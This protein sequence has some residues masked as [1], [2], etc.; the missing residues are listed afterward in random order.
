MLRLSCMVSLLK[1]N[2]QAVFANFC[3]ELLHWSDITKP[4][5]PNQIEDLILV[6]PDTGEERT[7]YRS[8]YGAKVKDP[9][10][11]AKQPPVSVC[12]NMTHRCN[13]LMLV[14]RRRT[15][16]HMS[17]WSWRCFTATVTANS[18]GKT[19]QICTV[20]LRAPTF[21]LPRL[22]TRV[23]RAKAKKDCGHND[24]RSAACIV[25]RIN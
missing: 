18:H 7:A 24:R 11:K 13:A 22:D 5:V 14:F 19:L 23:E 16:I 9:A 4:V 20:S 25:N 1:M 15:Q 2:P 10:W 3:L 12:L 21:H 6:R 8:F 17:T